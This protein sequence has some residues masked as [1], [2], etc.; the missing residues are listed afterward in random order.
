M[1]ILLFITGI[2]L[3]LILSFV[4][5]FGKVQPFEKSQTIGHKKFS[6]IIPFRNEGRN[7]PALLQSLKMLSYSKDD[8]E[9][10]FIDDDS[11]DDS[12]NIIHQELQNS[13]V[14]YHIINNQ[15]ITHSPK[16]DAIHTAIQK[17]RY[18]WIITTDADCMVTQEWLHAFSAF[19][20][21]ND[22]KMVVGPVAY[23]RQTGSFLENFQVL[24]FLS[25]QGS[26]VGG[27][28]IGKPFLCNGANLAYQKE[29]FRELGGFDGNSNI[30]SGDDIFLFEKFIQR[31]PKHVSF[32]KSKRALVSTLPLSS[33]KRVIHQRMRW[34]AKSGSY[35]LGFGKFVGMLVFL[36]NLIFA[37]SLLSLLL[38]EGD[39][40]FYA[41]ILVS[42]FIADFILIKRTSLFYRSEK[43]K[44]KSYFLGSL[45]YPFFSVYIVFKTLTS[46]YHWKGRDFKK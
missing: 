39:T 23:H 31:Y 3:I 26:T 46:K 18:E 12:V 1:I 25:L 19:I 15:R 16:K 10:L 43:K 37:L 4:Y 21:E 8:F 14:N 11:S 17:A 27:F 36:T 35:Q 41:I 34:A 44:V 24:D 7:L 42:K 5:G 13:A 28:G 6:V 29:A 30:A 32:L 45:L 9:C 38:V 2:Y 22:S 40:L 33:W 20:L